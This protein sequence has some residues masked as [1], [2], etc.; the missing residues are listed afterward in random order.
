MTHWKQKVAMAKSKK[1]EHCQGIKN[2]SPRCKTKVAK[3]YYVILWCFEFYR[4]KA[5]GGRENQM[6]HKINLKKH[7]AQKVSS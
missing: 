4:G 2:V 3:F 5:R 1:N 6:S 7:I